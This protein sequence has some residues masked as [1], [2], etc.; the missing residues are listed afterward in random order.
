MLLDQ[1]IEVALRKRLNPE[2]CRFSGV[3]SKG[4]V[5]H[6]CMGCL[7]PGTIHTWLPVNPGHPGVLLPKRFFLAFFPHVS[8][9]DTCWFCTNLAKKPKFRHTLSCLNPFGSHKYFQKHAA[10]QPPPRLE[11]ISPG[12]VGPA[13]ICGGKPVKCTFLTPG[14]VPSALSAGRASIQPLSAFPL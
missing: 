5:T 6:S 3:S 13:S 7:Y 11:G 12:A 9:A 14:K 2:N 4:L 1:G 10:P 8:A